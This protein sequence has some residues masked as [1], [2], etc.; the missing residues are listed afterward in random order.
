MNLWW[1]RI[2]AGIEQE[3]SRDLPDFSG[4]GG[5]RLATSFGSKKRMSFGNRSR[6]IPVQ[7]D[8]STAI[9][10]AVVNLHGFEHERAGVSIARQIKTA[11]TRQG[12]IRLIDVGEGTAFLDSEG[13]VRLA[14]QAQVDIVITGRILQYEL[15]RNSRPNLP[16]VVGFPE[17]AA[18]VSAD[19]RIVDARKDGD[20]YSTNLKGVGRKG[21]GVRVFP[22]SGDDRTSYLNEL[23]KNKVWDDAISQVVHNLLLEMSENFK[24][25]SG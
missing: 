5:V 25:F 4:M 7:K 6:R 21:R 16:L 1:L 10:V 9:R 24:W 22:V 17:T 12:H 3:F 14:E 15:T 23:E 2:E 20:L 11:L 19:L 8:L 13:A 18:R